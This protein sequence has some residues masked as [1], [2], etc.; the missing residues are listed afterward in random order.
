MLPILSIA[1]AA[2]L[3]GSFNSAI[4]LFRLKGLGD[5]RQE[6]SGNPGAVNVFRVSGL[7]WATV[8]LLVD[9]GKAAAVGAACVHL[10]PVRAASFIGLILVL[11]NR[12][13]LFH[14]FEGGKG[15]AAYLGFTAFVAP[16]AAAAAAGAW[17]CV[18]LAARVPFIASFAMV[19]VL[20]GGTAMRSGWDPWVV[21]GAV[22]TAAFIVVAHRKNI[23]ELRAR[24]KKA[25]SGTSS[26]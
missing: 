2:Y 3:L 4:V 16:L 7:F 26:I 17:V 15:V 14:G 1:A 19:A 18:F 5:P 8:V 25:G 13:P 21:S 10:L 20:A 22:A 11:G 9:V 12:Y 23:A 24:K 6:Q